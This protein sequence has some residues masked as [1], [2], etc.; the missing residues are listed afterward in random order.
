MTFASHGTRVVVAPGSLLAG[1]G[2]PENILPP[3]PNH[4]V[5]F[6]NNRVR[7]S[8]FLISPTL[9]DSIELY[10]HYPTVR[11]QS[12]PGERSVPGVTLNFAEPGWE[13]CISLSQD[14]LAHM[15]DWTRAIDLS[16]SGDSR[17][18]IAKKQK[19]NH[20]Y[21]TVKAPCSIPDR[22]VFVLP[23]TMMLRVSVE[24]PNVSIEPEVEPPIFRQFVFEILQPLRYSPKRVRELLCGCTK[25]EFLA[26]DGKTMRCCNTGVGTTLIFENDLCRVW[27]FYLSPGEGG[28]HDTVH[29]HTLPYV[30]INTEA[31][32]LIGYSSR[33]A[34]ISRAK[35]PLP[36]TEL[37]K[38]Q[39]FDDSSI[40]GK[41]TWTDI[42]E[43]ACLNHDKY[44]HGGKNGYVDKPMR[45]Y[46]VELC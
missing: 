15:E 34:E 26:D 25:K 20:T 35:D 10:H 36:N 28:T 12:E 22:K 32:R 6:Q 2:A 27:D 17:S 5:L 41:V 45:E 13:S 40:S 42:P 44:S 23:A 33:L 29:H 43:D 8:S 18:Q 21:N 19:T 31:S 38:L 30:F 37:E 16:C 1:L 11:W 7:V 46:L 9:G 14:D 24:A 3:L 4:T 39:I